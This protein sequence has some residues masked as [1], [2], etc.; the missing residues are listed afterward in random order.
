MRVGA[1]GDRQPSFSAVTIGGT[2]LAGSTPTSLLQPLAAEIQ[3]VLHAPDQ[4]ER[5]HP[6]QSVLGGVIEMQHGPAQIAHRIILVDVLDDIEQ[7]MD[8]AVR[9]PVQLDRMPF[10]AAQR[11]NSASL[12][13]PSGVMSPLVQ[14]AQ[15]RISPGPLKCSMSS[16]K[17]CGNSCV[18]FCRS[19][20]SLPGFGAQR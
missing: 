7:V 14:S 5:F 12:A 10:E 9:I 15:I 19:A 3:P 17:P 2:R 1:A 6:L 18:R 4:A 16:P 13:L 11:S 20:S 8:G